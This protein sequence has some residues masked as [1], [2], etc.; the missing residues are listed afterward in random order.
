MHSGTY[1]RVEAEFALTLSAENQKPDERR[2]SG[3]FARLDQVCWGL[4]EAAWGYVGL[5]GTDLF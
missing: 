2:I 3:S 4:H 1:R 5:H